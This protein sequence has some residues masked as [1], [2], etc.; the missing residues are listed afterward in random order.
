MLSLPY[1]GDMTQTS[2]TSEG[3]KGQ[4]LTVERMLMLW[5]GISQWQMP[6]GEEY[7][8]QKYGWDYEFSQLAILEYRKFAYLALASDS[9]VT[10][11]VA[12]DE[13]W[14]VHIL[15]TAAYQR[16]AQACGAMLHHSPGMPNEAA[17]FNSQYLE[18]LERYRDVFGQEPP[19]NIWPCKE[20]QAAGSPTAV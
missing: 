19:A 15:H 8:K 17:S 12:V 3:T 18:T 7:L 11:S 1:G 4:R 13:V 14:H 20:H 9:E 5:R 2:D 6:F 10:P 16:F